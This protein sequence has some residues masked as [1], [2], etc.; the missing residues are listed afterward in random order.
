[1]IR[2][3]TTGFTASID[4][5]GVDVVLGIFLMEPGLCIN[6]KVVVTEISLALQRWLPRFVFAGTRGLLLHSGRGQV[7]FRRSH[8]AS[9]LLSLSLHL[10]R[11]LLL[12]CLLLFASQL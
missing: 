7:V 10:L 4:T 11:L 8:V 5:R 3:R 1:M 9:L 2:L 6:P 12:S